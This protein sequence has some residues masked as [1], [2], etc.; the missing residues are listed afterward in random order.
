MPVH[1]SRGA[2]A[3]LA[4]VRTGPGWQ[5]T[6]IAGRRALAPVAPYTEETSVGKALDQSGLVAYARTRIQAAHD[7][8]QQ[9]HPSHLG[10]CACGRPRPCT[11][12]T[13]CLATVAH[14]QA[15]LALIEATVP[16]P[17]ITQR[18]PQDATARTAAIDWHL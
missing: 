12:V 7:I 15:K 16:L 4:P 13:A 10:L 6:T 9:H 8:R 11:V 5:P 18:S 1:A 17:T 14:Y 3:R 2:T